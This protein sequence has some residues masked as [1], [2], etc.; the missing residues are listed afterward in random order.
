MPTILV[1]FIT[2][3]AG[4][5]F[6]DRGRRR[7]LSRSHFLD[8]GVDGASIWNRGGGSHRQGACE[9]EICAPASS[10]PTSGGWCDVR[11]VTS[12]DLPSA[13]TI[14]AFGRSV[15]QPIVE[16]RT[17][18]EAVHMSRP[19]RQLATVVENPPQD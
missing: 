18:D 12:G 15:F 17:S 1:L 8:R 13:S 16:I 3:H 6:R 5:R 14:P 19:W 2:Q 10:P 4:D 11:T 9:T 7:R